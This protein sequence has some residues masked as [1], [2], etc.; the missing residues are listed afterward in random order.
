MACVAWLR[1]ESRF[2]A[3]DGSNHMYAGKEESYFTLIRG[4]RMKSSHWNV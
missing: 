4:F 3:S 1:G 2:Y